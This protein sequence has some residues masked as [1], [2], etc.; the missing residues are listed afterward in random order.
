MRDMHDKIK[1][2]PPQ[3]AGYFPLGRGNRVFLSRTTNPKTGLATG[4]EVI[5]HTVV[6][7]SRPVGADAT[8]HTSG[9]EEV[10]APPTQN[11]TRPLIPSA[12]CR[13]SGYGASATS[14]G[15]LGE[16]SLIAALIIYGAAAMPFAVFAHEE[17]AATQ[18]EVFWTAPIIVGSA[19]VAFLFIYILWWGI[20][21]K[22]YRALA[23]LVFVLGIFSAVSYSLYVT[24][25][26]G[27]LREGVITCLQD[28]S[29][30]WTAH[31]HAFI[32]IEA[33][34]KQLSLPAET[35][36]LSL[37]HTHEE[38]NVLHWHHRLPYDKENGL[39]LENNPFLLRSSF[40]NIGV[41]FE[42]ENFFGFKNG[43]MCQGG[44]A[45]SWKMFV[46]GKESGKFGDYVWHDR[47]V[48]L[49]IF[50]EKSVPEIEGGLRKNPIVFPSL[51]RG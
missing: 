30:L 17:D 16:R 24:L 47:D 4:R 32:P 9:L 48:I 36:S 22:R 15:V 39:L 38:R 11:I 34:G 5:A 40:E 20:R 46:N 35:G 8:R 28:G 7:S 21:R 10:S 13:Q 44:V 19:V 37:S 1:T 3:W 23:I 2:S 14:G 45:G 26:S 29:C 43:D 50:D 25:K 18:S 12:R 33:C 6:P 42:K 27:A 49:F 31:V 51:G 41:P